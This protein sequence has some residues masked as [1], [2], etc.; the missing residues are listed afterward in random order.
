M[1]S[2]KSKEA[3]SNAVFGSTTIIGTGT[4]IKGDIDSKADIR[5][6]GHII[7][8][9]NTSAKVLIG[10]EGVVEGDI[11]GQQADIL[12]KVMG[13]LRVTD[14]L[15]LRGK[16]IVTGNLYAGKLVVEPTATFNG[17]CHMGANIVELNASVNTAVNL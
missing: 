16:S 1:F 11:I 5:L 9:I 13:D 15:Q 8:N 17:N 10:P 3:E 12:G 4:V 7:G 6:D 14:L 2:S